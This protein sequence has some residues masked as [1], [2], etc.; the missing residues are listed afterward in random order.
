MM[1][2]AY[3]WSTHYSFAPGLDMSEVDHLL[4]RPKTT[5]RGYRAIQPSF[6]LEDAFPEYE[7][8]PEFADEFVEYQDEYAQ[9]GAMVPG[10][11]VASHQLLED[12]N[13]GAKLPK[14]TWR[15][16]KAGLAAIAFGRKM[17]SRIGGIRASANRATGKAYFSLKAR[18]PGTDVDSFR[19]VAS[20]IAD[21][22]GVPVS[23]HHGR[24]A[25]TATFYQR[26][27]GA[28]A[29]RRDSMASPWQS[30][31][32]RL[33]P[34]RQQ[35]RLEPAGPSDPALL[36][37]RSGSSGMRGAKMPYASSLTGHEAAP[38]AQYTRY[39][40]NGHSSRFRTS[41]FEYEGPAMGAAVLGVGMLAV[42]Y[43]AM[44]GE[45]IF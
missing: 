12:A 37:T 26:L 7:S 35:G 33:Y 24:A 42:M 30:K 34:S 4:V 18:M 9:F 15:D 20:Q 6:P 29:S 13:S 5:W 25:L 23:V 27:P 41:Y 28:S 43:R 39:G 10:Y 2:D 45:P 8:D 21:Q 32:G 31:F 38:K 1:S 11:A 3:G 19:N 16:L 40:A 44:G 14:R 22:F 36:V 17:R